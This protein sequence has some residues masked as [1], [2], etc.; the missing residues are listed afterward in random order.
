MTA[1]AWIPRRFAALWLIVAVSLLGGPI[2]GTAAPASVNHD[3]TYDFPV[4]NTCT[5]EAMQV[6]GTGHAVI[7][8]LQTPSGRTRLQIAEHFTNV[9]AIGETSGIVYTPTAQPAHFSIYFDPAQGSDTVTVTNRQLFITRSEGPN[10]ILVEVVH[11]TVTPNGEVAVVHDSAWTE[12][13]G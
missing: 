12:C 5:G 11:V 2:G 8:F 1:Q 6:E 7:Q 4:L 3:T 9:T 13:R 10:F